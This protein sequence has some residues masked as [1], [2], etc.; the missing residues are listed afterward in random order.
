M[1]HFVETHWYGCLSSCVT[2]R[3]EYLSSKLS[4]WGARNLGFSKKILSNTGL[5]LK[6]LKNLTDAKSAEDLQQAKNLMSNLLLQEETHWKQRAKEFWLKDGDLNTKFFLK[7]AT[8][9]KKRN[10]IKSLNDNLGV[11]HTEHSII[12]NIVHDYFVKLFS[13]SSAGYGPIINVVENKVKEED[14]ILL[15]APFCENEFMKAIFQM[16]VDKSLISKGFN[17]VFFQKFWNLIGSSVSTNCIK[18]MQDV[19]FPPSLNA[20]TV[21]LIPKYEQPSSMKDLRPISLCNA[22]Y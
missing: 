4:N 12:C 3:L 8:V 22:L 15:M 20:T 17:P 10:R 1:T 18:C 13:N 19:Q 7:S 11:R 5:I 2:D 16:K 14:N 6:G 21:V 9:R